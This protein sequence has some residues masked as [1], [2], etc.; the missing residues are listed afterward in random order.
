MDS[1]S[2]HPFSRILSMATPESRNYKN[3]EIIREDDAEE[4]C[5]PSNSSVHFDDD[6]TDAFEGLT[7]YKY[8]EFIFNT[9]S[10][11]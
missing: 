11:C 2:E 4:A 1:A 10:R 6:I 5:C 3:L 9:L 7:C 8:K